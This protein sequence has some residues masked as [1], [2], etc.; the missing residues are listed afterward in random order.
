MSEQ[1]RGDVTKTVKGPDGEAARFIEPVEPAPS[2]EIALADELRR[3]RE[4]G[5]TTA[6]RMVE[7]KP[8]GR[9]RIG[10][11]ELVD[12]SSDDYLGLAADARLAAAAAS[13]LLTAPTGTGA[14]RD[15]SGNHPLHDLLQRELAQYKRTE[16]ALLFASADNAHMASIPALVGESDAVYCDELSHYSLLE[17]VRLSRAQLRVFPHLAINEL[18]QQLS[19]D[20]GVYRRRLIAVES[21]FG[22]DAD[23]FPLD[24][25]VETARAHHA[26]TYVDE[27][28]ATGVI[29]PTGRGLTEHFDVESE[30]DIVAGALDKALGT[31]GGFVAGRKPVIDFFGNTSP[32]FLGGNAPPPPITAAALEALHI[33]E[34]DSRRRKKL[35]RNAERLYARLSAVVP[36][37]QLNA[38][39]HTARFIFPVKIGARDDAR[40]IGQRLRDRGFLVGVLRPSGPNDVTRLRI[41]VTAVHNEVDIDDFAR[42]AG[43]ELKTA[44]T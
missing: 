33:A 20:S 27:S 11:E 6:L 26:W 43:E 19:D 18:R 35:Q 25:L 16:A 37:S 5:L 8:D 30:I 42:A 12:F 3:F 9:V 13:A 41:T 34:T 31:Q 40:R 2:M 17:A 38:S 22:A 21:V 14:S 39:T 15:T 44:A 23:Y 36:R 28:H 32:S 29:G 4:R 24:R 7:R 1:R 10:K